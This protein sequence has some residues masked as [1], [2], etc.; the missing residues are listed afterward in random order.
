VPGGADEPVLAGV[1]LTADRGSGDGG[2]GADCA[3]DNAG[4]DI[5]GPEAAAAIVPAVV[6]ARPGAVIPWPVS[7]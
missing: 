4:R 5:A 7:R 1:G 3:A 6:A 2:R